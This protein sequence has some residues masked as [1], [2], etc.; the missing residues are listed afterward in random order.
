MNYLKS[1]TFG[2]FLALQLGLSAAAVQL[3]PTTQK[4]CQNIATLP[5]TGVLQQLENGD[6]VLKISDNYLEYSDQIID[7]PYM[8]PSIG[9]H[10]GIFRPIFDGV[11]LADI[12]EL[13][14][15]FSFQVM[16]LGSVVPVSDRFSYVWLLLVHSPELTN[17]RLKYGLTP[18]LHGDHAFHITLGLISKEA[19]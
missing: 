11:Q 16:G 19:T 7:K 9:A 15:E 1:F 6:I 13:G 4:F 17:L 5:T 14:Q 12:P 8:L 2:L 18:Y 10:I 3:I